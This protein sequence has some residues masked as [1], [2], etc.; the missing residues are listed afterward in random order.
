MVSKFYIRVMRCMQDDIRSS[1]EEQGKRLRYLLALYRMP[2]I[3]INKLNNFLD[4]IETPGLLDPN[5]ALRLST[6]EANS[7][8][9]D[10]VEKDLAWAEQDNCFIIPR[11][12]KNYPP[13][14]KE[15]PDPP[16]LLFV[17]GDPLCLMRPQIAIVGS[18]NPSPLGL[19]TTKNFAGHFSAAGLTVT[20]GLAIGIDTAGHAAAVKERGG[21]IAVLGNSLETVYPASNQK[22]SQLIVQ[23]GALVSEFPIGTPAIPANFPRR[24]RIIS[25][26]SL[27]TLVVEAALRSG[28]LITTRFALEQGREVFA[29]PGSIHS[30][31]AKGCHALI[32]QG[33]KLVETA[34]DVLEEL[35]ALLKLVNGSLKETGRQVAVESKVLGQQV[36]NSLSSRH[37]TL[38]AQVGFEVTSVDLL[39]ERSGLTAGE[40][41]IM[42]LELELQSHVVAVPGGFV[43]RGS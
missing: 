29:I 7:V 18:R 43:R 2:G 25:G 24:N 40:V 3:G 27:G 10:G 26:L 42:L 11:W 32:R 8:V 30:P 5:E 16:P 35:S 9:W 23:N 41:S 17:R 13:L 22:L 39:V 12:D 14:L 6:A 1:S 15:I 4:E 36:V 38:L 28:S 19:E 21:T 33:A 34:Q 37:K 31:L 20:S